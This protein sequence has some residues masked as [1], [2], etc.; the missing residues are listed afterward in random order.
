MREDSIMK[1]TAPLEICISGG[2]AALAALN[3]ESVSTWPWL[4]RVSRATYFFVSN[5]MRYETTFIAHAARLE[6]I[7]ATSIFTVNQTHELRSSVA[8]VVRR[9]VSLMRV[10]TY[11][12]R[13]CC[14]NEDLLWEAT[15]HL[16]LKIKKSASGAAGSLDGAVKTQNM[17]GSIWSTEIEPT[18]T[19]FVRSYLYGT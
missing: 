12:H 16:G 14:Y 1:A 7:W 15:S 17:E 11:T 9:S 13:R 2:G 4:G 8:V 10:S 3:Y 18:L 19:N 5:A 6:L